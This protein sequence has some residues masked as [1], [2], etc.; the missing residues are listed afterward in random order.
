MERRPNEGHS[1]EL[2]LW[3]NFF[4]IKSFLFLIFFS[5]ALLNAIMLPVCIRV[6][7]KK[8]VFTQRAHNTDNERTY[9]YISL[10]LL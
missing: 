2:R 9:G 5:E 4:I 10:N 8:R 7:S 6:I 3:T 1:Y